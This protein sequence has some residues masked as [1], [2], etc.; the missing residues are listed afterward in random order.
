MNKKIFVVDDEPDICELVSEG[1]TEIGYEVT[2]ANTGEKALE[3]ISKIQPNLIIL[4]IFIPDMDGVV[5]YQTLRGMPLFKKTPIIFLTALAQ[6]M[7]PQLA[8][9]NDQAYSVLP[10]PISLEE[11]QKEVKR[12]LE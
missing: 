3:E 7:R 11:I 9:L 4:D 6:G 2:S 12:L 1:L 10:K 5:I 8:G